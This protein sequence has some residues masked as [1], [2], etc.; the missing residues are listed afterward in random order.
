MKAKLVGTVL[1]V[2]MVCCLTLSA[3]LAFAGEPEYGYPPPGAVG[4]ETTYSSGGAGGWSRDGKILFITLAV[5]LTGAYF[6]MR[7][8]RPTHTY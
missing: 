8:F 4:G 6:A 3:N 1:L 5:T 7:R 2:V